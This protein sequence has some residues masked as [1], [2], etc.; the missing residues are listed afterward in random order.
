MTQGEDRETLEVSRPT[1]NDMRHY[2]D[3]YLPFEDI[4][5]WLNH[6]VEPSVD[7]SNREFA[8]EHSNGAYQRYLSFKNGEELKG[9]VIR[10][11]PTRFEVGAVYSVEPVETRKNGGKLGKPLEKELVLDI[12]V[13]DYDDVRRCCSGTSICSKCWKFVS[14]AVEIVNTTL[15]EDFGVNDKI[16]V[17]SGRRGVHC[18]VSDKRFR[19]LT[20]SGRRAVVEYM[21]GGSGG[22]SNTTA[23]APLHPYLERT[24]EIAKV[25]FVDVILREQDIWASEEGART[26]AGSIPDAR[27]RGELLRKWSAEKDNIMPTSTPTTLS[28]QRWLDVSSVYGQLNTTSFSLA[29]WKRDRILAT[30]APRLD[31]EVT[32]QPG[33]LL[34]SPFC[35]HP[36]TGRVCV[37]F[38]VGGGGEGQMFNPFTDAPTVH[39]LFQQNEEGSAGT[40]LEP[41]LHLFRGH[42]TRVCGGG[43]SRDGGRESDNSNE[44]ENKENAAKRAKLEW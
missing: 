26:L 36:G 4:F 30:L 43:G 32:R 15:E 7:F 17:F 34:K 8:F 29:G 40:S 44:E 12:D 1:S 21:K 33:H 28:L 24:L 10:N 25:H 20:E 19:G 3:K 9:K 6:G 11:V 27:L 13:T 5:K 2:Y 42:V 16:W 37:P 31:A 18:W 41:S 22:S 39:Q 38:A 14:I 35:V 23:N